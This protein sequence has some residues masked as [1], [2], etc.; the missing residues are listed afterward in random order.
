[1]GRRGFQTQH[2]PSPDSKGTTYYMCEHLIACYE[3]GS[4]LE[5]A[6]AGVGR[7]SQRVH[8]EARLSLKQEIHSLP[9]WI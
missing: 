3:R 6:E 4:M 9:A 7:V 1:M 8:V 2:A 5:K